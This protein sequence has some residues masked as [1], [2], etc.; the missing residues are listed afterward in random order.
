MRANAYQHSF[1]LSQLALDLLLLVS[2]V[3][4]YRAAGNLVANYYKHALKA[5]NLVR[6]WLGTT[7]HCLKMEAFKSMYIFSGLYC[8]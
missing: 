6:D 7:L 1:T 2:Y 5:V 8:E 4:C 3:A